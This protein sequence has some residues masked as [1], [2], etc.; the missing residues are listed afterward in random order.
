MHSQEFTNYQ[1]EH[2]SRENLVT[3]EQLSKLNRIQQLA[4]AASRSPDI[5]RRLGAFVLFAGLVDFQAI[6]AAR[7]LEKII[8]KAQAIT[9]ATPTLHPHDDLY[10]YRK[11][12]RTRHIFM[13]IRRFLPFGA[14]SSATVN[15]AR[16]ITDFAEQMIDTGLRFYELRNPIVHRIG[17][18]DIS[19]ED[20]V[21]KCDR[22]TVIFG[23]FQEATRRFFEAARPF[24]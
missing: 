18:P 6:Q 24:A 1:P 15:Q 11:R 22:A 9:G 8:L 17:H 19:F 23:E 5:E 20:V 16:E 3:E 4:D 2:V 14:T 21:R 10:F 13:E 7:L 12:I